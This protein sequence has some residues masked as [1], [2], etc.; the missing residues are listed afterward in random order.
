MISVI[1]SI[2]VPLPVPLRST[3]ERSLSRTSRTLLLAACAGLLLGGCEDDDGGSI[4]DAAAGPDAASAMPDAASQT[5][6]GAREAGGSDGAPAAARD[7]DIALVRLNAD[8]TRDTSFGSNGIARIDFGPGSASVRD[9][10]WGLAVDA[11]NR[12]VLFGSKKGSDD[13]VDSDRVVARLQPSGALDTTFGTNGFHVLNIANLGDSPR[14][15]FVQADGKIVASGYTSQ[16]TGVGTQSANRIVLL[17]LLDSGM[18][19]M[20]FGTGGVVNAAP[21]VPA[22]PDTTM[23]GM[24]EAYSVAPQ[25]SG[26]YVTTGYGRSAAMGTVDI[27]SFRFGTDG[28][29]DGTWAG[30][31]AAVLDLIGA[32][33]RGRNLVALGDDSI[34]VVGSGK[35]TAT[36]MDALVLKLQPNGMPDST[37]GTNGYK[38][39]DSGAT[40]DE[41][42]YGVALSP[43]KNWV[44][45]TGY[46]GETAPTMV[47]DDATL[48]LLPVGAGGGTEVFKKVPVSESEG[49]RFWAAA[50]DA[51]NKPYGAGYVRE[52]A[53]SLMVVARFNAD[54]TP[55]TSFGGGAVR[56]NVTAGGGTAET[57]RGVV[58]Q[59]D[60]KVVIAGVAEVP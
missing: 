35:P 55:D 46:A 44:V 6:D 19:D 21:F 1:T 52:G 7:L 40:G 23:W 41:P 53:D 56:V 15:G 54:G 30:S 47:D 32:D 60:G 4:P 11:Q 45:A 12:L 36:S 8:G 49:D 16:P 13:R 5:P 10:L 14:H 39:Y 33:D 57:A 28:K 27:V 34:L 37:F 17:R 3:E 25:S 26:N 2:S 38:L 42:F 50:F 20:T 29:R 59:S 31:G 9:N 51:S 24:A 48:L 58:I 43:D 18:P 22:M